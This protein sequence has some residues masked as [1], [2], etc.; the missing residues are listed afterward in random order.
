SGT[1]TATGSYSFT[2]TVTDSLD[3]SASRNYTVVINPPI[4]IGAGFPPGTVGQSYS[5]ALAPAVSGGTGAY[6]FTATGILPPVLNLGPGGVLAGIPKI[7]GTYSF[8]LTV[9]DSVGASDTVSMPVTIFP[10][11]A[12]TTPSLPYGEV[13]C[14]YDQTVQTSGGSAPITFTLTNGALPP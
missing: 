6:T 9:T 12:I 14:P 11:L 5:Y 1:P 10:A 2:I 13:D 3:A 8:Q 4:T 7:A